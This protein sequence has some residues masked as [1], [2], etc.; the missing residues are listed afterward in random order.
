M[1]T[2][3]VMATAAVI[4]A[5]AAAGG[6]AYSVRQGEKQDKLQKE[7]A[8]KQQAAID[9]ENARS[10]SERKQKINQMRMQMG[11]TGAGTRG[12]TTSGIRA[13]VGGGAGNNTL[14]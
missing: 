4:S 1:T 14:G 11:G 8:R 10:L 6:T 9:E 2:G 13:S 12:F 7:E 5:I 3:A